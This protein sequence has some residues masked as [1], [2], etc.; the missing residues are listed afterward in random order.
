MF[1]HRSH[2]FPIRTHT[3]PESVVNLKS[4]ISGLNTNTKRFPDD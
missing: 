4:R 3:L 2:Q 1:P